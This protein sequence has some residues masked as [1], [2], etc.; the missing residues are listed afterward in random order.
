M[1]ERE[2]EKKN[3]EKRKGKKNGERKRITKKEGW[4]GGGNYGKGK[5]KKTK[6]VGK[7]K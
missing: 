5:V 7:Q 4:G 1:E 3:G 2:P 6:R